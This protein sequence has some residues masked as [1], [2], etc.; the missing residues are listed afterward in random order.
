MKELRSRVSVLK[1]SRA[2]N[3]KN[4]L[5]FFP[6]IISSAILYESLPSVDYNNYRALINRMIHPEIWSNSQ[7]KC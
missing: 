4:L 3:E 2:A 7:L 1:L 5:N 6:D